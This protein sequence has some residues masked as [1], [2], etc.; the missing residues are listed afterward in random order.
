MKVLLLLLLLNL[1]GN[2]GAEK[3]KKGYFLIDVSFYYGEREVD[4]EYNGEEVTGTMSSTRAV[5]KVAGKPLNFLE[6]FGI[7]GIGNISFDVDEFTYDYITPFN[8][9][10]ELLYG[11]GL[12]L[13][14]LLP[15]P[16]SFIG[17]FFEGS[18][19]R[20]LSRDRVLLMDIG[21]VK[22]VVDWQELELKL[23][24]ERPFD[25]WHIKGGIKGSELLGT[26]TIKSNGEGEYKMRASNKIGIFF[27]L[28]LFLEKSQK[29]AFYI[30][31]SAIDSNYFKLG[32]KR[33][34]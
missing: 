14:F 12:T 29:T 25:F 20:F 22:E 21:W 16:P 5:L 8:G 9:S 26:D 11:G 4:E 23:G 17:A 28:D 3:I 2:E 6:A 19:Q 7:L 27:S 18:Y 1:S 32:I 30:D 33:W 15:N 34:L 13:N 24:L 31:I 10:Y